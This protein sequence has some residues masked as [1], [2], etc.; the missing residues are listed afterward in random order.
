M[1]QTKTDR[2]AVPV[3]TQLDPEVIARRMSGK[4]KHDE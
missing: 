4:D 2:Q 3:D 1:N